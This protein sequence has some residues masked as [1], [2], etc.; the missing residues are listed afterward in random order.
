MSDPTYEERFNL[1]AKKPKGSVN[2]FAAA[3]ECLKAL[4]HPTRLR[5]VQL[6][7][8]DR[9]SVGEIAEDCQI[10]SHVAS[11][12]LRLLQRCGFLEPEREGKFVFYRVTEPHL[13]KIM[14]CIEDRF[15]ASP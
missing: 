7:L 8:T 11:E 1:A 6:L 5:I 3:A 12:H 4:A 13:A 15:L 9:F 10:A 14:M 2:D